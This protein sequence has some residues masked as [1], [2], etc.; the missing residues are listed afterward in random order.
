[1]DEIVILKIDTDCLD[2]DLLQNDENV[3]NDARDT[4][5]YHGIIPWN[6]IS[7][8]HN[9]IGE[10][11]K[12]IRQLLEEYQFDDLTAS[13]GN[14]GAFAVAMYRFYGYP[15]YAYVGYWYDDFMEEDVPEYVHAFVKKGD[16]FID[17]NGEITENDLNE[18]AMFMNDILKTEIISMTEQE[19][20]EEFYVDDIEIDL[21]IREINKNEH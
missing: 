16:S 14:C 7:I 11:R 15:L 10:M 17:W 13:Q 3:R 1:M 8:M 9:N 18:R 19:I 21:V 12:Y 20:I 2:V 5:E 6:C 4:L